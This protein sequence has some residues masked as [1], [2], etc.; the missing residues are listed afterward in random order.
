MRHCRLLLVMCR[1]LILLVSCLSIVAASAFVEGGY[2]NHAGNIVAG[3]HV[4]LTQKEL[5]SVS[6]RLAMK[7]EAM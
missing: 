2:T 3:W 1:A 6:S 7:E 5:G 4:R